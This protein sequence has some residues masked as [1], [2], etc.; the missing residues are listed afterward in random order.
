MRVTFFQKKGKDKAVIKSET[1]YETERESVN[2]D[3]EVRR[4]TNVEVNLLFV[5]PGDSPKLSCNR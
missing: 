5:S 4:S 2:L 3:G 1:E